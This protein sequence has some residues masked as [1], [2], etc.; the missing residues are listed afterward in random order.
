MYVSFHILPARISLRLHPRGRILGSMAIWI[1]NFG[2]CCQ[3]PVHRDRAICIPTSKAQKYLFLYNLINVL[4][5]YI[6]FCQSNNDNWYPHVV[7]ISL[8]LIRVRLTIFSHFKDHLHF[9]FFFCEQ[10]ASILSCLVFF[11]LLLFFSIL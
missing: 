7:L 8:F 2:R 9:F 5:K 6:L 3:I 4:W 10:F 1:Y 11:E